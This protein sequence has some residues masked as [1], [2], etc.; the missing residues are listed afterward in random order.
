M[1]MKVFGPGTPITLHDHVPPGLGE[2]SARVIDS[3]W[4]LAP[5]PS[6]ATPAKLS[7]LT[8]AVPIATILRRMCDLPVCRTTTPT[9]NIHD[10]ETCR[11]LLHRA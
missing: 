5:K 2:N 8:A 3:A 9:P 10:R 1:I 4:A 6:A 11:N 7:V